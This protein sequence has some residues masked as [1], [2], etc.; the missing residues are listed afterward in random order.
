M[1]RLGK[2]SAEWEDLQFSSH[3]KHLASLLKWFDPDELRYGFALLRGKAIVYCEIALRGRIQAMVRDGKTFTLVFNHE[4]PERSQCACG[5]RPFCRHMAAVLLHIGE[6]MK[7][8]ADTL[9]NG[10][11]PAAVEA[12]PSADPAASQKPQPRTAP[13]DASAPRKSPPRTAPEESA[14]P[15]RRAPLA[16][17]LQA[18]DSIAQW[19]QWFE[20]ICPVLERVGFY[21]F[22]QRWEP[23]L[24]SA[25]QAARLWEPGLRQ[26]FFIHSRLYALKGFET[27][28]DRPGFYAWDDAG[29]GSMP[30]KWLDEIVQTV[31][32]WQHD[33]EGMRERY[34]MRLKET[35]DLLRDL[36][37]NSRP[38]WNDWL[39]LY[40]FFWS[41]VLRKPSWMERE[42]NRLK[43]EL[44]KA[45]AGAD[46]HRKGM[47]LHALAN[48]AFLGGD[49]ALAMALLGKK[50]A[51]KEPY[52]FNMFLDSL[53]HYKAKDRLVAWLRW[54]APHL[55][56]YIDDDEEFKMYAEYWEKAVRL[57][58]DEREWVETMTALL[59]C[60]HSYY[61]AYL[62]RRKQYKLWVDLQMTERLSIGDEHPATIH[63]IESK[64]P[65]IVIPW[66]HQSIDYLIGHRNRA[67]YEAAAEL[68]QR[69]RRCY[70]SWGRTDLW[71]RYAAS[72]SRRYSRSRSLMQLLREGRL[73]P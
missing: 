40:R 57:G 49:D 3:K 50:E 26:L 15:R 33:Y 31:G 24:K 64:T 71:E 69:L 44:N 48:F 8:Q 42:T 2:R 41:G 9:L 37:F 25:D 13:A 36:L 55:P 58:A 1:A 27:Q 20:R 67:G 61:Q 4:Q 68:L 17:L 34:G 51:P 72:L 65:E 11:F 73:I 62:L 10:L 22:G 18:T 46:P 47:A 45:E 56:D 7:I 30:Q 32:L 63:K 12:S 70:A 53:V 60:S 19:Q 59:P 43:V 28:P 23:F 14:K 39:G 21:E 38:G 29:F 5:Q 54:I 6:H 66:Y 52:R 16:E 35:G